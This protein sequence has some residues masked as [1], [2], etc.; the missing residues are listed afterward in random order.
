MHLSCLTRPDLAYAVNKVSQKL[1]TP[2][3]T[4]WEAAKRIF[5]YL[6]GTVEYG[7]LFQSGHKVGVLESFSDADIAGDV[8]IR[9]STSGV[10]CKLGGGAVCWI[11]QKQKSVSLSTTEAEL[12]AVNESA[13]EVIWLNRLLS[14]ISHLEKQP[15]L[16]VDNDQG[17]TKVAFPD[18]KK[19][20][21]CDE[22]LNSD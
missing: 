6:V 4:D 16:R 12:I 1:G 18:V 19:T 10:V 13:K 2:T 21:R 7:I 14:E 17:T 9:R 3:K 11:S 20:S 8:E 5:K 15:I 22:H